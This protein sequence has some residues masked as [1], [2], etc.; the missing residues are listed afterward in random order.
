MASV[1]VFFAG[2]SP[3]LHTVRAVLSELQSPFIPR[4]SPSGLSLS[5]ESSIVSEATRAALLTHGAEVVVAGIAALEAGKGHFVEARGA[6]RLLGKASVCGFFEARCI[7]VVGTV[8]LRCS[9][10]DDFSFGSCGRCL[11]D[12]AVSSVGE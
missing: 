3:I 7:V 4:T 12:S 1:L 6:G 2:E 11:Q 9:R 5:A 8:V 10:N